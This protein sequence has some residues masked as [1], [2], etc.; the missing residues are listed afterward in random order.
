M[1]IPYDLI[2]KLEDEYGS[3]NNV[4]E[5]NDI[6][7]LI[8]AK[9][10]VHHPKHTIYSFDDFKKNKIIYYLENG[11]GIREIAQLVNVSYSKVRKIMTSYN[12][13]IK[14]K[15]KYVAI[16]EDFKVYSLGLNQFKIMSLS[17]CN[18][19]SNTK[20]ALKTMGYDLKE[21]K[22]FFHWCDLK[23]DDHYIIDKNI[24]TKQ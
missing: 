4:S 24:Y 17:T 22:G 12:L 18:N 6:L 14:P 20:K 23:K 11:Y 5:N 16:G 10:H 2:H 21:A 9:L 7:K 1:A 8:R 19:F 15:F 13:K 3:M